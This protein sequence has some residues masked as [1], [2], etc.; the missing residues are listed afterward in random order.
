[1]IPVPLA[2]PIHKAAEH[3]VTVC[4]ITLAAD[5]RGALYWRDEG[6]LIVAGPASGKRLELRAA[7][8][9][10]AALRHDGDAG[11]P[12]A[13]DRAL[14]AAHRDRARRQLPRRRRACPALGA[15]PRLARSRS[16]A[17]ATGSGLPAT[18]IPIRRTASVEHLPRCS[19]SARSPSAIC[20]RAMRRTARSP[21]TCTR[22]RASRSA[23]AR[24]P[25]AALPPTARRLVMPA[26]GAYTGG[27]NI[28]DRAFATVFGA[29]KVT[30][31]IAGRRSP[32][33]VCG[34]A[35]SSGLIAPAP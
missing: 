30:A 2:S 34:L 19:R 31:H 3:V 18:T 14:R 10:A 27:L 9:V 29:R 17:G 32:L 13:A 12:R 21:A 33:R 25:A 24:F 7:R 1:M 15:G 22:W 6:A 16:S 4:G 8:P 28:R 23:A 5:C 35:L 26:L 20:P 11:A